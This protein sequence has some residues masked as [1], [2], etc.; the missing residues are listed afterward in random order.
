LQLLEF[1]IT[2]YGSLPYR[3]TV[4]PYFCR[5]ETLAFFVKSSLPGLALL[6]YV[7]MSSVS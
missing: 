6:S 7:A 2:N 5:S 3:F 4:L 1:R